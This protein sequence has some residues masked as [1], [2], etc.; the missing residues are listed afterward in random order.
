MTQQEQQYI[1]Q[2]KNTL[3]EVSTKGQD[4]ILMSE[5]LKALT[6][7][8]NSPIEVDIEKDKEE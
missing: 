4:T 6:S 1:V 8:V 2:I 3:M 7:L 5:C